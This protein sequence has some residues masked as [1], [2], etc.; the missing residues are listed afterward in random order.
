MSDV[1]HILM[2]EDSE[3]DSLLV[4]RALRRFDAECRC[5]RVDSVA[6]LELALGQGQWDAILCDYNVPQM[7][8]GSNLEKLLNHLPNTPLILVTGELGLEQ[9]T[10]MLKQGVWDFVLKDNLDRLP[11][12]LKRAL[13]EADDHRA[14]KQAEAALRQSEERLRLA[15][16]GASL[17]T[18]HL[19][20]T[21]DTDGQAILSDYCCTLFGLPVGT[22]LNRDRLLAIV[23]PD[24]QDD[25][26]KGLLE[27]AATGQDYSAEYRIIL[28]DGKLRWLAARAGIRRGTAPEETRMEGVLQDITVR[29]EAELVLIQAKEIAESTNRAKVELL[30][31]MSHEL[32]TP[33]N[34]IFGGAQL[35]HMTT[36]N[37]EQQDYLDLIEISVG[38]ELSLVNDLLDL[39]QTEASGL[40]IIS[41]EFSLRSCLE[42]TINIQSMPAKNRRLNLSLAMDEYV[43]DRLMGDPLRLRQILLN[44]LGNA[45]KFTEQGSITLYLQVNGQ[46]EQGRI[47]LQFSVSDTG[48]GI[49]AED[50]ERIFTPFEQV[51]M[52]YTR[53]YGGAGLGLS[54]CRRLTELLGGRLW[55]ESVV[56][57]GSTFHLELP[58]TLPGKPLAKGVAAPEACP[59]QC[60]ILLVDDDFYCLKV[61]LALLEKM[62]YQVTTATNGKE[63][64]EVWQQQAFDLIMMDIQMPVMTG[65]EALDL[66]RNLET[67]RG[68]RRTPIIAQTAY[69]MPA[70]RDNL[71][72]AGF[73]GYTPK[74]LMVAQVRQEIARVLQ[75]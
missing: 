58:F 68:S 61:N 8:F 47:L 32:R 12:V 19:E 27:A 65:T 43:H 67:E 38:N 13:R 10:D 57:S 41:K 37:Q 42:D 1:L 33:L 66:I 49:A 55:V 50:Y 34:G 74:P 71:L 30:A 62:G 22:I 31:M 44:L 73:D 14:R 6:A 75:G 64:V 24:D 25:V 7:S 3:A 46:D 53:R 63:A 72:A 54:I 70:D 59:Q 16:E 39:A 35:L 21:S 40:S 9:A 15:I 17:G 29:K 28:P 48:I 36:L 26:Y 51:D 18:W 52:S 11:S 20:M 4:E 60:S 5:A 69:A 45:I 56:G 23:H 2:V